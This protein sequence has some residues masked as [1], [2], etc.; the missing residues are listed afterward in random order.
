MSGETIDKPKEV[1]NT[2]TEVV[3]ASKKMGRFVLSSILELKEYVYLN[4]LNEM[5]FE[6]PVHKMVYKYL[7]SKIE[8]QSL[9]KKGDLFDLNLDAKDEIDAIISSIEQV[10]TDKQCDYYEAC[11]SKLLK[12]NKQAIINNLL[13]EI[14]TAPIEKQTQLKQELLK[15]LS[16][17]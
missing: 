16:N 15:L 13:E 17:K 8:A 7:I 6:D 1:T 2:K 12:E 5:L 11:I 10:P 4:D 9:P 14:K 3:S